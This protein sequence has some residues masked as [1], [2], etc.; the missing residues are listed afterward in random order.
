[1]FRLVREHVAGV[2]PD[3]THT[4]DYLCVTEGGHRLPDDVAKQNELCRLQGIWPSHMFANGSDGLFAG[5][6]VLR[7][8]LFIQHLLNSLRQAL[9]REVDRMAQENSVQ[10][11]SGR[12]KHPELD[13][14]EVL[15]FERDGNSL[16]LQ[17]SKHYQWKDGDLK[18]ALDKHLKLEIKLV[19]GNLFVLDGQLYGHLDRD[20]TTSWDMHSRATATR[21]TDIGGSMSLSTQ[22]ETAKCSLVP[23]FAPT[24]TPVAGKNDDQGDTWAITQFFTRINNSWDVGIAGDWLSASRD[25]IIGMLEGVFRDVNVQMGNLAFVPPGEETFFFRKPR[26]NQ[27]LDLVINVFHRDV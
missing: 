21:N 3:L 17:G 1:M 20:R 16:F 7:K 14:L 2:E 8:D 5:V 10:A 11:N 19:E 18:L 23:V 9:K 25:A 24:F 27:H 15:S 26:F 4:I 22:G 13:F 6:M 12:L